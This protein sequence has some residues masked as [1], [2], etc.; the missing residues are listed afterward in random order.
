MNKYMIHGTNK[1]VQLVLEN[2]LFF[3]HLNQL[4]TAE[5]NAQYVGK[6]LTLFKP[7]A[8]SQNVFYLNSTLLPN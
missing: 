3:F 6:L 5:P 2:I 1:Q 7:V 8:I 4:I